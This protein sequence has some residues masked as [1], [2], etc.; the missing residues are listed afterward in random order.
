MRL[1]SDLAYF[2]DVS[3][4]F[5]RDY[6]KFLSHRVQ[7]LSTDCHFKTFINMQHHTYSAEY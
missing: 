4:H 5:P 3:F 1:V 7:P 6:V 2:T